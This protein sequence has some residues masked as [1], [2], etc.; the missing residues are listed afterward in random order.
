MAKTR[1]T[2]RKFSKNSITKAS[3]LKK[4][5]SL[6]SG[7]VGQITTPTKD[8]KQGA[9]STPK[10]YPK[11]K[12]NVDNFS[13]PME[14]EPQQFHKINHSN[15]TTC[16]KSPTINAVSR[17]CKRSTT[18][19]DPFSTCVDISS[20]VGCKKQK[21]PKS[22]ISAPTQSCLCLSIEQNKGDKT[23]TRPTKKI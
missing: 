7:Y 18:C 4:S 23:I 9:I 14:V 16:T 22:T 15:P 17:L 6:P 11:D 3:S 12:M 1:Q 19:V 5:L 20:L 8:V 21:H 2:E 10:K 13:A